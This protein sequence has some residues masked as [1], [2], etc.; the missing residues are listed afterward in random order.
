MSDVERRIIV[1]SNCDW[2]SV[3]IKTKHLCMLMVGIMSKISVN[4]CDRLIV[5]SNRT[6]MFANI[7]LRPRNR[8]KKNQIIY[9]S[10]DI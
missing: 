8:F 7:T 3:T 9:K 2:A 1:S 5:C 6:S 4:V 10:W